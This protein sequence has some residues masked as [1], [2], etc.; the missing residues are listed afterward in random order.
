MPT[1]QKPSTSPPATQTQ[2]QKPAE[3]PKADIPDPQNAFF[4]DLFR[5]YPG[6]FDDVIKRKNEL[7]VQVIYTQIDRDANNRPVFKTHTYNKANA[8]YFYPA[9]TVK[10][11]TALLALQRLN[12]LNQPGLDMNSTMITENAYSGQTPAYNDPNTIDGKPSIAQYI[13]KILLVSDN[14]AYNRLY[15]FLGPDYINTEMRK[16]GFESARI[17]H[18]LDIFLTEDE[19]KHTNPIR[20]FD[21]NMRKIYEQPLKKASKPFG[22]LDA[23]LG[24]GYYSKG[25]LINKPLSFA[26]K[27]R[28]ELNDLHNVLIST[29]FPEMISPENRFNLTRAQEDFVLKYMSSFPGESIYP[30]YDKTYNDA[31]CKFLLYGSEGE[32]LPKNIRIFNKVGDAYGH[33]IDAAYIVDFDKKIEFLVSAIIYTN[34]DG[35][36]NDDKYDYDTVGFP[37]L[38]NLGRALYNYE[39]K[40]KR[41]NAPDLSRFQFQYDK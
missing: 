20:F 3:Q 7:N 18:R 14:D 13:K 40:R 8:K 31:Y 34:S 38:K 19:N 24:K 41:N 16:K 21:A 17:V 39:V 29:I 4:E 15:E 2:T 6:V 5:Q 9:S 37:F 25:Q 22:K 11:P 36:L 33:L 23:E 30:S 32:N 28:L 27:N 10:L 12:E 35:I 1:P 26:L